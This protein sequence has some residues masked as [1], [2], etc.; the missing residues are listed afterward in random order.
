MARFLI[1]GAA[2][3]IGSSLVH[4]LL[5]QGH[6]VRGIDDLSCGNMENL[7][8]VLPHIDFNQMDINNTAGLNGLVPTLLVYKTYL[9]IDKLDPPTPSVTD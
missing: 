2:G 5:R 1:T 3:F 9:R 8:T 6:E 4:E 7:A